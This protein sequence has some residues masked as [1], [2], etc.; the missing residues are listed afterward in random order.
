MSDRDTAT[1]SDGLVVCESKRY[2]RQVDLPTPSV[3]LIVSPG[4]LPEASYPG[5]RVT[6]AGSLD[7]PGN[8]HVPG[9]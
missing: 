5:S 1:L 3:L 9:K 4:R 2:Q 6:Q 8:V 7:R